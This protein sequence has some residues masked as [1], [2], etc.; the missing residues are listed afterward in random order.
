MH[1]LIESNRLKLRAIAEKY[2][3]RSLSVFGSMARAEATI[4]SDVDLL[5][6]PGRSLSGFELGEILMDAQDLLKRKV[7]IVTV[8]ALHPMMRDRV[9]AEAIKL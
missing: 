1:P 2:G 6:E 7:D 5:I 4:E 9:L 3:A 8:S